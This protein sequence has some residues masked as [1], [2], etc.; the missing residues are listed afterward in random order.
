MTVE[1]REVV[2]RDKPAA[3]LE[4]SP[5]GTVPV[6]VD[7]EQVLEESLDIMLWALRQADPQNWLADEAASLA[8]IDQND[9]VF[10]PDLDRTKYPS[11]YPNN[12][13]I[14]ARERASGVLMEWNARIAANGFLLGSRQHLADA[15]IAPFVRQFAHIDHD[16]FA[17]QN[18][19]HLA[20][21]L[22]RFLQS[23]SFQGI[24]SKFTQWH[25]G[26]PVI[27][28]PEAA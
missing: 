1:L 14:Q 23:A 6:L 9:T 25:E 12:D 21:W 19:P 11:R 13:P 27:P 4:A 10:K 17:A 2:L 20:K 7:G 16:W 18:W 15:A 5:K 22:E 3:F 24:M 26:D 28:F 8:L